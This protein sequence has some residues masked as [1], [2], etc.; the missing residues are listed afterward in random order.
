[1]NLNQIKN[2]LIILKMEVDGNIKEIGEI[3]LDGLQWK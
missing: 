1:M 3:Q 2:I